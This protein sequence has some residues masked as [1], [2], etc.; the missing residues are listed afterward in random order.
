[1]HPSEKLR[2]LLDVTLET[3]QSMVK[4]MQT[5]PAET[6]YQRVGPANKAIKTKINGEAVY[7]LQDNCRDFHETGYF[8]VLADLL[9]SLDNHGGME[10]LE[11]LGFKRIVV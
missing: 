11:L 6:K 7:N 8:F 3:V 4:R 1:M 2:V 9:C 5:H 10:L